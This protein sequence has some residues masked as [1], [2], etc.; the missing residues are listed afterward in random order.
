MWMGA[1]FLEMVR[2][3]RT[4][5]SGGV[6]RRGGR[7][8]ERGAWPP[9]GCSWPAGVDGGIFDDRGWTLLI[10]AANRGDAEIIQALLASGHTR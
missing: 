8:W 6:R 7:P 3:V 2:A 10:D 9:S 4:C 5:A 1:L